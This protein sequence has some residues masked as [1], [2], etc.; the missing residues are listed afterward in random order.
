[1]QSFPITVTEK[2]IEA[3]KKIKIKISIWT[4]FFTYT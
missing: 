4:F 1:M 2:Q 3:P